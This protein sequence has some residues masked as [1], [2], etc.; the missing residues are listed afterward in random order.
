M[1]EELQSVSWSDYYTGPR[2]RGLG[3]M[4]FGPRC[5][6]IIE[7]GL[8]I[9]FLSC[10]FSLANAQTQQPSN[11]YAMKELMDLTQQ[12]GWNT[13]DGVMMKKCRARLCIPGLARDFFVILLSWV[14]QP[15]CGVRSLM[16]VFNPKILIYSAANRTG[17]SLQ[18]LSCRLRF[19]SVCMNDT[20]WSLIE[21]W[22]HKMLSY[23]KSFSETC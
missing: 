2:T 20:L 18:F 21:R 10:S 13:Q 12:D 8:R 4:I 17:R 23:T 19:I 7:R 1:H 22:E 11:T 14:F 16:T 6:V 3:W 15:S 9:N 5:I